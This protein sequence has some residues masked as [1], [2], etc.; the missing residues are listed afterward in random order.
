MTDLIQIVT[1]LQNMEECD[2]GL[3]VNTRSYIGASIVGNDC[4]QYLHLSLRGFPEDRPTP[5][6]QRIFSVGHA[7]EDIVVDDLKAH[8]PFRISALDELTGKQYEY[9]ALGDHLVC[10]LDGILYFDPDDAYVLEIKTMNK[11]KF[12]AFEKKGVKVSHPQYFAQVSLAMHLSGMKNSLILAICKD[13]CRYHAEIVSYDELEVASLRAKIAR[14]ISKPERIAPNP[15][16]WRCRGCFKRTSCWHPQEVEAPAVCRM[17]KHSQP[18]LYG[19]DKAWLCGLHDR[20]AVNPC[21][22]YE[23]LTTATPA[24]TTTA[25]ATRSPGF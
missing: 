16:D 23:M 18:D 24:S 20:S 1:L 4:T 25:A 22:D 13:D 14:A 5:K 9:T 3:R 8:Q 12:N 15:T 10:H 6:L 21:E 2:T 11:S 17:C 7:L 19:Q